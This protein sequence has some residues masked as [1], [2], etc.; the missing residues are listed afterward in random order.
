MKN[1]NSN[2]DAWA[3]LA[4]ELGLSDQDI[5]AEIDEQLP[6]SSYT[7]LDSQAKTAAQPA[8]SADFDTEETSLVQ[9]KE[10]SFGKGL[11]DEISETKSI[12]S[13][14]P[15]GNSPVGDSSTD[16]SSADDLS[17]ETP[18]KTSTPPKPRAE[19]KSFFDRFPKINMFGSS[20]KESLAA[21]E[22]VKSP[23][24]SGKSFT[25][26]RLERLPVS[27]ERVSRLE[28]NHKPPQPA[29]SVPSQPDNNTVE[30]VE[31]CESF[32]GTPDQGD[33][34]VEFTNDPWSQIAT[35]VGSLGTSPRR[36]DTKHVTE[37]QKAR[38]KPDR[39]H[40]ETTSTASEDNK[41]H[42]RGRPHRALPSMFDEQSPE[43]EESSVLKNLIG[44]DQHET[45]EAERR[46]RSMFD[47]ELE[48]LPFNDTKKQDTKLYAKPRRDSSEGNYSRN[49]YPDAREHGKGKTFA[50]NLNDDELDNEDSITENT[51]RTSERREYPA[52][53]ERGR[54]GSRYGQ[55]EETRFS[56]TDKGTNIPEENEA[57]WDIEEESKPVER[58]PRSR[59][60]ERNEESFAGIVSRGEDH[61]FESETSSPNSYDFTQ[62]HKNIPSWD[63]AINFLIEN[64]IARHS[65]RPA[66]KNKERR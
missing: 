42:R 64:N 49:Q 29:D 57:E 44:T 6:A 32:A 60:R 48:S 38:E 19:K 54:R 46:L 1:N 8:M 28:K 25:S 30:K 56:R 63:D 11:M 12:G 2:G 66:T 65:Q 58:R 45:D 27:R 34:T 40:F 41:Y 4:S 3:S 22:N 5:T 21:V 37:A 62:I 9:K 51:D 16:N 20:A 10:N 23:S 18:A 50:A 53:R 35:Q 36:A 33:F 17:P 59:R 7:S 14:F 31:S 24:L 15:T 26:N 39:N 43:S 47:E 13:D 52:N 55:R 61:P